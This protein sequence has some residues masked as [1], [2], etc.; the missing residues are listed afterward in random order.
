MKVLSL[1]DGISC[2]LQ[3]LKE[4]NIEVEEYYSSEIDETAIMISKK[5]HPD[6][7]HIGDVN[8]IDF[9]QYIGKIDLLL[10]GSP[11]QGFSSQGKLKGFDDDRSAL[12]Y[13]F[14]EALNIIKPKYFLLENVRT[15]KEWLDIIDKEVGVNRVFIDSKHFSAQSRK[16][17]YWTNIDFSKDYPDY[18]IKYSDILE[19]DT[20]WLNEKQLD[21]IKAW[22]YNTNP[23]K[24]ADRRIN[25][26]DDKVGTLLT[27]CGQGGSSIIF[28]IGDKYRY[29]TIAELERLQTLP[30]NYTYVDGISHLKRCHHIGN[31]WNVSTINH[32]LGGIKNNNSD[33][34][35]R[36]T[37]I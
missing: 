9:T 1:F 22:K 12:F 13:K 34:K 26:N 30:D 28:K 5:N 17:F 32:I 11:C 25:K 31:G 10:A 20:N 15:K 33:E 37:Q 23:L 19:P 14:I 6:I 8:N 29:A 27:S 24:A 18:K 7:K 2:G 4:L 36:I 21:R 35:S 16:R 3:S